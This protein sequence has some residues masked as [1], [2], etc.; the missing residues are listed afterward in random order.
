MLDAIDAATPLW[1]YG[2]IGIVVLLLAITERVI[3]RGER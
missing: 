1:F 2:S 3:Q